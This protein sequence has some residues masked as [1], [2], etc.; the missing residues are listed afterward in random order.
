MKEISFAAKYLHQNPSPFFLRFLV[1]Y[2]ALDQSICDGLGLR[3]SETP[4]WGTDPRHGQSRSQRFAQLDIRHE[5]SLVDRD[6][7]VLRLIKAALSLEQSQI[8][9]G[10]GIEARL[11]DVIGIL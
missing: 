1:Y 11:G 7:A 4:Q 8:V 10:A 3:T 5:L 6:L 2:P 9:D